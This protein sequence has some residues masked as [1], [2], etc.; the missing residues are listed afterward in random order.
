MGTDSTCDACCPKTA[1]HSE[2]DV[3][4]PG[5]VQSIRRLILDFGSCHD[6]KVREFEPHMGLCADSAEPAWDSLSFFLSA[7][8]PL[9]LAC[10][11][12]LKINK[13]FKKPVTCSID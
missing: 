8:L 13:Y 3:G 10:S 6:L 12:S 2:M 4:T 9:V 5:R 1:F 11:L 7:P